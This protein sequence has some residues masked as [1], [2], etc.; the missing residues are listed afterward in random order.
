MPSTEL[1][2]GV[3]DFHVHVGERI[4]GY[5]LPNGFSALDKMAK[6]HGI[7]AIGAFVTEEEGISLTAKLC[8]MQDDAHKH[9]C[10]RVHWH[11]TP[12]QATPEEVLALVRGGCDVKLYT[13]Y[14]NAGL[15]SSY[16]RIGRWMEDLADLK[17]RLLVHCEDNDIIEKAGAEHPFKV[18]FDH[19]LRRPESA[20]ITAVEKILD[21]AVQHRYPLHIVHVSTPQAA[22]LIRE[23][24]THNPAITCETA[25]HYLLYNS[26]RLKGK[27][28]HRWLCSPPYRSE[29]SRGLLVELL[30]D[31]AFDI[32]ASDHCAFTD[33]DKDR[34]RETPE[35]VPNGIPGL[36]MM[37]ASLYRGLVETGRISLHRLVGLCCLNPAKLMGIELEKSFTLERLLTPEV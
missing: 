6:K 15:Y 28:A 7:A 20:E 4:G 9:F 37:F 2:P 22:L 5:A 31:G 1:W 32:V 3:C 16:K 13:T 26:E 14:K 19:T 34:Y 33:A 12:A 24:K 10:G 29:T 30:Q 11:L 21:L 27:N 18:P 25:P 8:A 17:P 35:R 36:A 23:A